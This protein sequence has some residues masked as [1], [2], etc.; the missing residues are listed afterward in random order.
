MHMLGDKITSS[1]IA[2]SAGVPTLPWSGSGL[3]VKIPKTLDEVVDIP[4]K[5]FEAACIRKCKEDWIS[6]HDQSIR[7]WWRKRN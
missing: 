5:V 1:I 3:R 4:E 2:E 6:H 7:R